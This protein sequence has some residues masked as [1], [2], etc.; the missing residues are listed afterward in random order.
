MQSIVIP[1]NYSVG[2]PN[3]HWELIEKG[4]KKHHLLLTIRNYD[5]G[6]AKLV[7]RCSNMKIKVVDVISRPVRMKIVRGIPIDQFFDLALN[8]RVGKY[9][10]SSPEKRKFL[11]YEGFGTNIETFV[12]IHFPEKNELEW[13][14]QLV[15]WSKKIGY[16]NGKSASQRTHQ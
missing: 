1:L 2:V 9:D 3:G 5:T 16:L 7:A 11:Q 4:V 14:G 8:V 10:L 6:Q 15:S 13:Q 12:R